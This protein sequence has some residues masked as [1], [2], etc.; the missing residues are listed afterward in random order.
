MDSADAQMEVIILVPYIQVLWCE[1]RCVC[2][3]VNQYEPNPPSWTL[4]DWSHVWTWKQCFLVVQ[5]Y[6]RGILPQKPEYARWSL[7]TEQCWSTLTVS[8]STE[9]LF[10]EVNVEPPAQLCG[11]HPL[12]YATIFPTVMQEDD[13][14]VLYPALRSESVHTWTW[15]HEVWI[16]LVTFWFQAVRLVCRL[17]RVLA[18]SGFCFACSIP[19][20]SV[21][22]EMRWSVKCCRCFSQTDFTRKLLHFPPCR[23]L[24]SKVG[25]V[26]KL[27]PVKV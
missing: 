14:V 8:R 2:V 21:D 5:C 11:S 20:N 6:L 18:Y 25:N 16:K 23:R 27:I 19:L 9:E 12:F 3:W 17:L 22:W 7:W 24:I 10:L 15:I 1:C 4:V 26:H 13:V